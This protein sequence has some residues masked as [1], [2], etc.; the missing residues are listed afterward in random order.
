MPTDEILAYGDDQVI[1]TGHVTDEELENYYEISR[2]AIAP[3]RFGAGIKG[4]V[5]E[6]LYRGV[7]MVTTD[8]GAESIDVEDS[9]LVI[10]NEAEAFA[11]KVWKLY[12]DDKMIDECSRR[13]QKYAMDNFGENALKSLF[14]SQ[15]DE[16]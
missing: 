13:G 8:I 1:V 15:M 5:L 3:L 6:S 2:V 10:A 4:K 14:Q 9:G 11:E 12:C 7:P 16:R